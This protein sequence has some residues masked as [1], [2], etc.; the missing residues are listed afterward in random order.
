MK[1]ALI[2]LAAAL[3]VGFT[4]VSCNTK[5]KK[6]GDEDY[7]LSTPP[8]ESHAFLA[9]ISSPTSNIS[10][11]TVDPD[12]NKLNG[13]SQIDKSKGGKLKNIEAL[14]D[15]TWKADFEAQDSDLNPQD[16]T[17]SGKFQFEGQKVSV[18]DI[19]K[20]IG[21][22]SLEIRSISGSDITF[23][24]TPEGSSNKIELSGTL[25]A[26]ISGDASLL[27]DISRRWKVE[28][29]FVT[30]KSESL[31]A[32]GIGGE[33]DGCDV[34]AIAKDLQNQGLNIDADKAN[35]KI[36]NVTISKFGTVRVSLSNGDV[37]EGSIKD[38][39]LN[40]NDF[41]Y[42]FDV[43]DKENPILS[44]EGSGSVKVVK[45]KLNLTLAG[46]LVDN[47]KKS[48]QAEVKFILVYE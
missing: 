38:A 30:V 11:P 41:N 15:G 2:F 43:Y 31:S 12:G 3:M 34:A 27:K 21:W 47:A 20:L 10:L 40:G 5:D 28:K 35:Y 17:F 7:T 18:G 42:K 37:I 45:G 16:V 23:Y 13:G 24:L 46:N 9:N 14:N 32:A 6:D 25:A 8:Q 4:A 26:A 1:K 33:Y 39:K 22:G 19:Y 29:T 44:G 48:Y 36:T